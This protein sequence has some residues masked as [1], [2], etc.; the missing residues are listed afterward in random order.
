[1]SRKSVP[2][3]GLLESPHLD[4]LVQVVRGLGSWDV[5]PIRW[6]DRDALSR[7]A[8]SAIGYVMASS[9][10]GEQALELQAALAL[11]NAEAMLV[12]VGDD[13]ATLAHPDC[14]LR[15]LSSPTVLS[16]LLTQSTLHVPPSVPPPSVSWRRKTDMIIGNSPVIQQLLQSLDR[17]AASAAPVL[18]NGESGTGKE[19]VARALHYCG[20]RARE[21]FIAINCAAI[22]ETLFES[23]LFGYQR[24]AFTG[25]TAARA[26]AFEAAHK[27]TLFLDEIGELPLTMQPKLLR[28]LETGQVTRLGSNESKSVAVRIVSATNRD[29]EEEVRLGRFREDLYYRLRVFPVTVPPLRARPEDIAPII[30]HHLGLISAR[31][32]R[33]VPRLTPNALEKLI[34][35]SW[36]GNVRELINTLERAF[37][38]G[39]PIDV[40]HLDLSSRKASTPPTMTSYREARAEF[41]EDYFKQLMR[42]SNGNVSFAAKLSRKTRKEIYDALKRIGL[43]AASY[44]S[45]ES[46]SSPD[47]NGSS[48]TLVSDD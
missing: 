41:E 4:P 46:P 22:P 27:G 8:D 44:R 45:S 9:G 30:H 28:A 17:V 38:L 35:H 7:V 23:E 39:N 32:K 1:M 14:W 29:L 36:R 24:G 11:R 47:T 2:V 19:L 43:D 20:P 42:V 21:P 16:T 37:V 3:C 26:G 18:I 48:D 12:V 10:V 13:P 5:V 25:A 15:E 40:E 31:E 34:T 6:P 33:P